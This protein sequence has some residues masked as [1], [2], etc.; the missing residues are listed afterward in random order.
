MCI[1]IKFSLLKNSDKARSIWGDKFV[2]HF[3]A[4]RMWE[5]EQLSKN[6]AYFED[7]E[8]ISNWELKR[9]FEII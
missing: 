7:K 8:E 3:S 4:T 6:R 9:Y 5:H 2:D 1:F